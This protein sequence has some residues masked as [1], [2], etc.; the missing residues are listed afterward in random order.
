MSPSDPARVLARVEGRVQGVGFRYFVRALACELRLGGSVRNLP[1]GSVE[2]DAEGPRKA[3]ETLI[4]ELHRG[5]SSAV[6]ER[7]LV[8]WRPPSGA[9]AFT[10]EAG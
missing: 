1:T 8:E 4:R 5:P 10:I 7:V 2:V 3:L 6:V 9:G